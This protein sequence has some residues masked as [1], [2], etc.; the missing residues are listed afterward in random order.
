MS[1][2]IRTLPNVTIAAT[3][4]PQ[5]LFVQAPGEPIPKTQ[6]FKVRARTTNASSVYIGDDN[7]NMAQGRGDEI[8]PGNVMLY[9]GDASHTGGHRQLQVDNVYIAGTAGDVV[10]IIYME[11]L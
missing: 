7:I 8:A 4:V 5:K 10:H 9:Q 1:S 11:Y 6:S 2:R 3:G